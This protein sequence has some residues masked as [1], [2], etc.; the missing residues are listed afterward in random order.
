MIVNLCFHGIGRCTVER[1]PGESSSWVDT[2]LF[3]RILDL[4]VGRPRVR[5]TFD[6]GNASDVEVALPALRER[7]LTAAFFPIAGRLDVP[8]SLSSG[9]LRELRAAGMT[10][11]SHGWDHVPWRSLDTDRQRQEF[12]SA[13][14]RLE[15]VSRGPVFAA[16]VPF[17]RYDRDAVR[18][19]RRSGYS[20]VFTSDAFPARPD[21]WL[22]ARYTVRAGDDLRTVAGILSG[23]PG[24]N[25]LRNL[26][27]S[28]MKRLA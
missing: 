13:R 6:D 11:G 14:S 25:E 20:A 15:Q 2:D 3:H 19:L 9:D 5:L 21:A 27:S 4:V 22:Q 16:S 12:V 17:G 1:E 8:G 23:R 10:L 28:V 24:T 26:A 18:G 7:G